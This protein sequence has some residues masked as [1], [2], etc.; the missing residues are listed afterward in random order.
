MTDKRDKTRVAVLGASGMLGNAMFRLFGESDGFNVSGTIR[1][2]SARRFFPEHLQDSLVEGVDVTSTD[3]LMAALDKL[4][5]HVI[6]NCVG[7]VK[8]LATAKDPLT[9]LPINSMLPHRLARLGA[10]IQARVVHISTDCVF[11]GKAGL[12]K[13]TDAPDALDLYGRSKLLGELEE[14][15]SITLRTSIIGRELQGSHSLVDWFLSQEGAV[16]GYQRAIFSGLP[17]CELARIVRDYVIPRPDLYGLY[18]VSAEP[19]DKYSLLQ[20]IARQYGHSIDITLDDTVRIDRSLDST[21]FR[22]ATSYAPPAWPDLI[23]AMHR[24]G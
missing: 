16:K 19:I 22:N 7:V 4:R 8:Q 12:Y 13:E 21:R 2:G 18:H 6:I 17:T 20:E 1:S 10:L 24:F 15:G 11:S 3:D 23:A 9:T 14:P 5:P